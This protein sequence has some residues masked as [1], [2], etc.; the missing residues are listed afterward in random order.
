VLLTLVLVVGAGPSK[1]SQVGTPPPPETMDPPDASNGSNYEAREKKA[2]EMVQHTS[3]HAID[4]TVA[5]IPF[6][7][8]FRRAVGPD[9][10][11]SW[12]LNDCGETGCCPDAPE[13]MPTCVQALAEWGVDGRAVVSLMVGNVK[14]GEEGTPEP[15]YVSA[16]RGDS[17]Q[18]YGSLGEFERR[19]RSFAEE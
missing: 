18:M 11:I 16:D 4:S 5:D 13:D 8:W 3:A 19:A 1:K 15:F 12:E 9:A 14:T 17:T 2:V 10:R 7:V 6:L